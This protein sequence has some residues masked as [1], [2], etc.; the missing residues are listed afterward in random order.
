ME[1][2]NNLAESAADIGNH[3]NSA[4]HSIPP[5]H[6]VWGFLVL[7]A[8][9]FF[10]HTSLKRKTK[11]IK[12][13]RDLLEQAIA[14]LDPSKGLEH[15]LAM[16]LKVMEPL[17]EAEGY[18]FYLKEDKK[19]KFI[20]KAVRHLDKEEGC[21]VPSC[22]GLTPHQKSG[23]MPPQSVSINEQTARKAIIKQGQTSVLV[24]PLEDQRGLIQIAPVK[25]MPAEAKEN[26]DWVS[27][28]F[29][30]LLA[31]VQNME[32]LQ[33][34]P[35]SQT[36]ASAAVQNFTTDSRDFSKNCDSLFNLMLGVTG[37]TGGCFLVS[38]DGWK[39]QSTEDTYLRADNEAHSTVCR[40][41]GEEGLRGLT[42]VERDFYDLPEEIIGQNPELVI[43]VEV[44]ANR[45]G[46]MVL[47]F[48]E[49]PRGELHRFT[50][51]HLVSKRLADLLDSCEKY[52]ELTKS[53]RDMLEMIAETIDNLQPHTIGHSRLMA[54]FAGII[55][56]EMGLA[57]D[58]IE[59]V[60]LAA[61]FSNIGVLGYTNNLL[62]KP[63]Q[64]SE[65]EYEM[66]KLHAQ[67]GASIIEATLANHNVALYIKHHHERYDGYGYPDGLQGEAIPM[68]AR[69]VAAAQTFLAKITSRAY[70][71]PLPLEKAL[72]LLKR[73]SGIELDAAAVEALIGW[74]KKAQANEECQGRSLMPCW[75]MRC[76]PHSICQGCPAFGRKD[77]NCWEIEGVLCKAHGNNC[78]TCFVYT[79][80]L[81]RMGPKIETIIDL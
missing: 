57:G 58:V 32:S 16:L 77:T 5:E 31:V 81:Y 66:M 78:P 11:N 27:R 47:W 63:G 4:I 33:N 55:A 49:V 67:V 18:Y 45:R 54:R 20:L 59:D 3:L 71:E 69:I 43:L 44:P 1:F 50:G 62:F 61:Y 53:Y 2:I 39:K 46:V 64:Y 14:N 17:V 38:E 52:D 60:V 13:Q 23:Y 75:D 15:S 40:I 37:A 68:G 9:F 26:L 34:K 21:A 6:F 19:N 73:A 51:L 80:Y 48:E 72:E 65:Q 79:E 25:K 8:L 7:L 41:L 30:A 70:R 35:D 29:A 24:I 74:F 12:K 42:R 56:R 10:I 76:V 22:S 36:A 28:T